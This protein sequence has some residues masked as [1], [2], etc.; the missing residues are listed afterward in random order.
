MWL[1]LLSDGFCQ[2]NEMWTSAVI[3]LLAASFSLV[4][5]WT[6][7]DRGGSHF[8][9]GQ[10]QCNSALCVLETVWKKAI[11]QLELLTHQLDTSK[12]HCTFHF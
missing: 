6:V 8:V 10:K 5:G 12:F 9:Q 7:I 3:M 1:T 2:F 4:R 11:E